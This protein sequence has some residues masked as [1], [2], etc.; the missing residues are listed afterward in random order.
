MKYLI[1]V[2]VFSTLLYSCKEAQTET[3]VPLEEE[4]NLIGE[5][6]NFQQYWLENTADDIHR[7]ETNNKHRHLSLR[8]A[9]ADG[10]Q[11]KVEIREG[12]N[13][14]TLI[15]ETDWE[16]LS[17]AQT[18]SRI[19]GD[20]LYLKGSAPF[21]NTTPYRFVKTRKFSGWI[22]YPMTTIKDSIYRNGGLQ[23]HDQGGMAEMDIEGVQYTAELTQLLFAHKL[24]I[25]KLAIYDMPMDSVQ[26]NSRSISYTWLN[27]EA[28]RTGINLRKVITGW[29]LIEPGYQNQNTWRKE[30]KE[31]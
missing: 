14:K 12:R 17:A 2:V 20:T 9:A 26:I 28:K 31:E 25:M 24:A 1:S 4:T 23:I 21:E 18:I 29:T 19:E 8:I 7:L 13:G 11:L 10:D 27:P 3:V 5:W 16:D 22:E 30:D 15:K 6:D